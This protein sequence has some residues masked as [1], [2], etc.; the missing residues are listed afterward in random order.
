MKV[1]TGTEALRPDTSTERMTE[2]ADA[3][4]KNGRPGLAEM[5]RLLSAQRDAAHARAERLEKGLESAL[6]EI[7]DAGPK[8]LK[9]AEQELVA[10]LAAQE[11]R[12]DE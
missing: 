12:D 5:L 1:E 7:R 9:Y 2:W 6:L 10:A 8:A 3:L 11:G 4:Q